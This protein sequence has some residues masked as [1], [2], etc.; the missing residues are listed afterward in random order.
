MFDY[1]VCSIVGN[2][3][4][5]RCASIGQPPASLKARG[6]CTSELSPR[7]LSSP[8]SALPLSHRASNGLLSKEMADISP[9]ASYVPRSQGDGGWN[10][11]SSAV[12]VSILGELGNH[13][14]GDDLT[15]MRSLAPSIVCEASTDSASTVSHPLSPPE[16]L[17]QLFG[18]PV[19]SCA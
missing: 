16:R 3:S 2:P 10:G 15:T 14:A 7:K 11:G 19:V 6:R 12:P 13:G 18:V 5:V 1:D 8:S 9:H 4:S 17:C